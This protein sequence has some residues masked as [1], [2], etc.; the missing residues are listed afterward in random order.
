MPHSAMQNLSGCKGKMLNGMLFSRVC[1]IAAAAPVTQRVIVSI[2]WMFLTWSCVV[3]VYL[4]HFEEEGYESTFVARPKAA[5]E[6]FLLH[7]EKYSLKDFS[8]YKKLLINKMERISFVNSE[9]LQGIRAL[10]WIFLEKL[11]MWRTVTNVAPAKM[12]R[13]VRRVR[14]TVL[15]VCFLTQLTSLEHPSV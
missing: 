15:Q 6:D 14:S 12:R 5:W 2:C 3:F 4:A 10:R 11:A 9:R 13:C 1:P 7:V 8:G